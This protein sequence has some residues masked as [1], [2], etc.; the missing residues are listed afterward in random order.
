MDD[1][2]NKLDLIAE[3]YRSVGISAI[4]GFQLE[5]NQ[6]LDLCKR[7]GDIL[8][9]YPNS[10]T[11]NWDHRWVEDH[12]RAEKDE[13]TKND[14]IIDWHLEH[15]D[16][17][18]Y[19][20]MVA[21]NWNMWNFKADPGSGST[22]FVDSS[23]VYDLL[24]KEDQ[25]FLSRCNLTWFDYDIDNPGSGPH[26]GPAIV[27]HWI[28]KKPVIRIEITTFVE[29]RIHLFDDSVPSEDQQ[30]IFKN[31]RL[32]IMDIIANNEEIRFVHEWQQ[33]DV[34]IPDLQ[35]MAHTVLGGF[36]SEDRTFTN[37][38]SFDKDPDILSIN[39]RPLV[40]RD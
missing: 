21:A 19:C 15:V 11:K 25:L 26:Y 13:K 10:N 28:S 34:V 6:Q 38:W 4:R 3:Q 17:D 5:E 7:L 29:P 36:K 30:L 20:K 9:W 23:E 8:G 27:P 39:E 14:I 32:K 37:F 16:Y 1:V 22:L 24:S 33:A 12:S 35:R 31:L 18:I 2:Y 40:W